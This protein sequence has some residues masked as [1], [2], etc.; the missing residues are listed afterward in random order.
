MVEIEVEV[1]EAV[2]MIV[3]DPRSRMRLEFLQHELSDPQQKCH[4]PKLGQDD[5]Q[6]SSCL[7]KWLLIPS[8]LNKLH[9]VNHTT[10]AEI[11]ARIVLPCGICTSPSE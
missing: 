10:C 4:D 3:P 11:W 5:I 6:L 9:N 8:D 2:D 7:P 1:D